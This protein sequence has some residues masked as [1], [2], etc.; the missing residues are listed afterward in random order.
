MSGKQKRRTGEEVDKKSD[1]SCVKNGWN[2][3]RFKGEE[4]RKVGAWVGIR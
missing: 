1:E 4:K 2:G 3:K